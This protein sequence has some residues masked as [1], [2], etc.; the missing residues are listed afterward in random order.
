MDLLRFSGESYFDTLVDL[1]LPGLKCEVFRLVAAGM[2]N[3]QIA[4]QLGTVEKTIK[5]HRARVMAKMGAQSVADLVRF[6]DK[7]GIE[8]TQK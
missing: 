1:N 8:A 4:F 2:L 5:V 7:L 6:A 3:K